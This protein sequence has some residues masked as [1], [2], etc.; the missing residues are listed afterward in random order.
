MSINDDLLD[1][2]RRGEDAARQELFRQCQTRLRP[3]FQSRL[4]NASDLEDCVSEVMA[5][6]LE[7]IDR[8]HQPNVLDAWIFGIARNVLK[9]RYEARRR[10]G[11]ELP[12]EL[13]RPGAEPRV[14]LEH[15]ADLPE[16]PTDL[17][18]L[19]GKRE[20]WAMVDGAID[21]IGAGLQPI[22]RE[23][24]KLSR[25]QQ[26]LVVGTELAEALHQPV[27]G[28]NRQLE[29]ARKAMQNAIAALVVARTCR[30]HC[31]LLAQE[32]AAMLDADQ[33]RAGRALVLKPAQ[34]AQVL[35]HAKSCAVCGPRAKDAREYSKW[36]LGP[37]LVGLRE[38]D[39]EGRRALI[40]LFSRSGGG[41]LGEPPATALGVLPAPI[42]AAPLADAPALGPVERVRAAVT[43]RI[44]TMPGS[45]TVVQLAQ[46]NPDAVRRVLTTVAGGIVLLGVIAIGLL[47]SDGGPSAA[48]PTTPTPT[49]TTTV[50]TTDPP[51]T[52][53][54][55]AS[56][57]P[58][59]TGPTTTTPG[60]IP[61]TGTQPVPA[62]EPAAVP[63]LAPQTGTTTPET[64]TT[65]TS[66][67]TPPP[68]Q[69]SWDIAIDATAMAYGMYSL[70]DAGTQNSK[71]LNTSRLSTGR[72]AIVMG[73]MHYRID[74]QVT[75]TGQIDYSP[76]LEA[77][78]SGR[79]T[80]TLAVH[81]FPIGIDAS[82]TNYTTV[83]PLPN[84]MFVLGVGW[85]SPSRTVRLL[86]G[87]HL[88]RSHPLMPG[89]QVEF[90]VT[91]SGGVDYDAN[92][93]GAVS[94]R[95]GP[96]LVLTG[97]TVTIDLS[98]TD[99]AGVGIQFVRGRPPNS[100]IHTFQLLPGRHILTN[101]G[102]LTFRVT[103]TGKIDFDTSLDTAWSGRGSATLVAH[104]LPITIDTS[105]TDYTSSRVSGTV[106]STASIR[107]LRLVPGPHSI[108]TGSANSIGFQITTV[109]RIDLGPTGGGG[110]LSGQDTS[111][112]VVTG[113]PITID[114]TATDYT[115]IGVKTVR[116]HGSALV[117]T[118][119]LVPG[120]HIVQSAGSTSGGS[121]LTF[122]GGLVFSV[123]GAGQ[124]A[125]QNTSTLVVPALP[126][127]IDATA[128]G[129]TSFM[130]TGVLP[131]DARQE[132]TVRLLAG[133]HRLRLPDGRQFDF[134]VGSDGLINYQP[135]LDAVLTGRGTTRLTIR[136]T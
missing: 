60:P 8:G 62:R 101:A 54:S 36:A 39:E 68:E 125:G 127:T 80:S 135:N 25:D 70:D 44:A 22:M 3:Y 111:T 50:P 27:T 5:R 88:V 23:H 94:G 13:P 77:I 65:T 76:S 45:D 53:Q 87:A 132:Q 67:V 114:A 128:T 119:R 120:G 66:P 49:P 12:A 71:Q 81:G 29:R 9:E 47:A 2:L 15:T 40:A 121:G 112:L 92:L 34:G 116:W 104:G 59:T 58:T 99:Y 16:A 61:S 64:T 17:E 129:Q 134:I 108:Q 90:Q 118:V 56:S 72:H 41:R 35:K 136:Q 105:A 57:P 31:P 19:L 33:G 32:M 123:N 79:N 78:V 115:G 97:F 74:F 85:V 11:G 103:G 89:G 133:L 20:L 55:P 86:P 38:D 37:G 75:D 28:L 21:G 51:T 1:R 42:A 24:I 69:S 131:L 6:A 18:M 84:S 117:G 102:G 106:E 43:A 110:V 95:G 7:G 109:G 83:G 126:I 113:F 100:P 82:A 46:Q 4:P 98:A 14:E 107:T 48:P 124:I 73:P 130:L 30:R 93:D 122:G 63:V 10:D 52:T 96:K 91:K 26:R